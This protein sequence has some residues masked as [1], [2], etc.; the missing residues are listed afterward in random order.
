MYNTGRN[1]KKKQGKERG[2]HIFILHK[3]KITSNGSIINKLN[4]Q[5]T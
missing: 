3:E 5:R 1:R 2:N 4:T